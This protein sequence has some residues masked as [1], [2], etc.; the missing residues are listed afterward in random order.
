MSRRLPHLER[1]RSRERRVLVQSDEID[2]QSRS[3]ECGQEID[4]PT[5][6]LQRNVPIHRDPDPKSRSDTQTMADT[7]SETLKPTH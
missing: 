7:A 6:F 1:W 4:I 5:P 3:F 2:I